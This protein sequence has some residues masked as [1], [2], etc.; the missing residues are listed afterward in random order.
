MR[1]TGRIVAGTDGAPLR[2]SVIVSVTKER[3]RR[4]SMVD[5]GEPSDEEL[6]V[7]C[8]PWP[9][10]QRPAISRCVWSRRTQAEIKATLSNKKRQALICKLRLFI[11][12]P[13]V[14]FDGLDQ[15]RKFP[16]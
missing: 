3:P 5:H 7:G 13:L 4:G 11:S 12:V 1:G 6:A 9:A 8:Q 14:R 2:P 15:T 10:E 16:L